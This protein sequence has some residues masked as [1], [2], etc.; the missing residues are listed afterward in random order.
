MEIQTPALLWRQDVLQVKQ[1]HAAA[2]LTCV[3][4][5][6]IQPQRRL[7]QTIARPIVALCR[8]QP[9]TPEPVNCGPPDPLPD[10]IQQILNIL[11]E[12]LNRLNRLFEHLEG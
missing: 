8:T 3:P 2:S 1:P 4:H 12:I 6:A 7:R 10:L 11:E 5:A 9:A